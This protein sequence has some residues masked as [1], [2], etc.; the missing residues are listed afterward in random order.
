[1]GLFKNKCEY[2]KKRIDRGQEVLRDVK[3]P[4]FVGTKEKAFCCE[5]HATYY[6]E[7]VKNIKK[8]GGSCCG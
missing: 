5:N 1:M 4:V 3:D 2:C 6:I 7:E 8:C